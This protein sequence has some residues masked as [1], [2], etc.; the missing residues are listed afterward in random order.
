MR[1]TSQGGTG[2]SER[3]GRLESEARRLK[4]VDAPAEPLFQGFDPR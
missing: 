4:V 3:L 1:T 2:S